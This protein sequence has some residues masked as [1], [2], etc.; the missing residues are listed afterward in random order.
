[1]LKSDSEGKEGTRDVFCELDPEDADG[2]VGLMRR[3]EGLHDGDVT[4]VIDGTLLFFVAGSYVEG[5]V[6]YC[7]SGVKPMYSNV[8]FSASASVQTQTT[9]PAPASQIGEQTVLMVRAV[10]NDIQPSKSASELSDEVFGTGTDPVNMK[11]QFAACSDSKF[12]TEPYSGTINTK[13]I[14]NGVYEVSLS[15][16][17]TGRDSSALQSEITTQ[18]GNDFG[19]SSW[20]SS[21]GIELVMY[22]L[23]IDDFTAYAYVP[24]TLSVYS[25]TWCTSMSGHM[26]EVGHV[27]S[28][29]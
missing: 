4:T 8:S 18:L 14:S 29:S 3:I 23:P 25:D 19:S 22:C 17:A 20:R 10:F 5:D 1:V 9:F 7:P 28:L 11:S 6:I 16:S 24:G 2:V 12:T 26:H 13:S 27:S 15:T 21:N